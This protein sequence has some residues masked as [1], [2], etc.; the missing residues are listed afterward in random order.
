MPGI[1]RCGRDRGKTFSSVNL[2]PRAVTNVNKVY[3]LQTVIALCGVNIRDEF[4]IG[5]TDG[6]GALVMEFCGSMLNNYEGFYAVIRGGS[7]YC[8]R[9]YRFFCCDGRSSVLLKAKREYSGDYKRLIRSCPE[10]LQD[11]QRGSVRFL[12]ENVLDALNF[13]TPGRAVA[14]LAFVCWLLDWW[15]ER[16]PQDLDKKLRV[17]CPLVW[18]TMKMKLQVEDRMNN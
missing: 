9:L 16:E 2:G 18:H 4:F 12:E 15:H 6:F 11:L 13:E 17:L 7:Q 3:D 1:C 10:L 8:G 5:L 14:S